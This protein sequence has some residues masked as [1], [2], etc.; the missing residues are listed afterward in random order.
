MKQVC[1]C[2]LE[3]LRHDFL[4]VHVHVALV[5]DKMKV[6]REEVSE[7]YLYSHGDKSL[8]FN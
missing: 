7:C 4:F 1:P 8:R 6:V 5:G 3:Q 2:P